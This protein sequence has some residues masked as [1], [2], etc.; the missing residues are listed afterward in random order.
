MQTKFIKIS[1]KDRNIQLLKVKKQYK[2]SV[3]SNRAED[4]T[5]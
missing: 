5:E 4:V 1:Q 3:L 2:S